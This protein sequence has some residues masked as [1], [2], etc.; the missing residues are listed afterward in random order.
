MKTKKLALTSTAIIILVV[1]LD[2]WLKIWIKTNFYLGQDLE[3]LPWFHLRFVQNP[4]MAFGME[5]GSKLFLTL[6]R[7]VVTCLGFW[8]IAR[9]CLKADAPTG[10]VAC[11]ALVIAGALGNIVDCVFYGEIFTNPYP[12]AVAALVPFGQGY[13]TLFHGYV[14][15]MFY[16]P[17]FSFDWPSWLPLLGGKEF[18]FFD[19][20]FNLADAAITCGIIA[21][22]LFYN[23]NLFGADEENLKSNSETK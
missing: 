13:G 5:L 11:V 4:G 2:Q 12:P 1:V 9:R 6:F 17:L 23:K 3:I 15:D 14:V 20:V 16:F 19:P 7:I 22:L 18:S 8:Y 21:I 10:Y